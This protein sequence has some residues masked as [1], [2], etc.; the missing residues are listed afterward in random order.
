MKIW[1]RQSMGY[2]ENNIRYMKGKHK[3]RKKSTLGQLFD[4]RIVPHLLALQK[5]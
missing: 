4:D 5:P 1:D 3:N 2:F